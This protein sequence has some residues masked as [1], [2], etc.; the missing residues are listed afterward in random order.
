MFYYN[1]LLFRM[2]CLNH[3]LNFNLCYIVLQLLSFIFVG[4]KRKKKKCI[5]ENVSLIV[6]FYIE[7]DYS[8]YLFIKLNK[9]NINLFLFTFD[10]FYWYLFVYINLVCTENFDL[11]S[12]S[13]NNVNFNFYALMYFFCDTVWIVKY[14]NFW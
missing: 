7:N 3:I 13:L 14:F 12:E 9:Y 2:M 5:S 10:C 1:F 4:H 6:D 11:Y 8:I